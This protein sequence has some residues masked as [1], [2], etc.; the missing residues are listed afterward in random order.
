MT[1]RVQR[2]TI[3]PL[4]SGRGV[5]VSEMKL[6]DRGPGDDRRW[7]VVDD[8]GEFVTQRTDPVLAGVVVS[9]TSS[10]VVASWGETSVTLDRVEAANPAQKV[11]VWRSEVAACD[12]G[13]V[14]ARAFSDLLGRPVRVVYMAEASE[15]R[16]DPRYAATSEGGDEGGGDLVSFADGFP[17]LI[18][19]RASLDDLVARSGTE[20]EMARFRANIVVDAAPAWDEDD[21]GEI[22][23][24]GV[25]LELVKP[26][27]R[28]SMTTLDPETG[29]RTGPEPLRTLAEFRNWDG[30]VMFGWNAIARGGS[31]IRVGD[32]VRVVRRRQWPAKP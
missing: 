12:T 25:R 4:K 14:A 27:S 10:G 15:R 29:T 1:I 7:M 18:A 32:E 21:W 17:Y 3:Y 20:L 2:L 19:N 13:D 23:I 11:T 24:G 5:S 22:A 16:I 9:P 8:R 28:C 6:T 31:S 30:E 26:C